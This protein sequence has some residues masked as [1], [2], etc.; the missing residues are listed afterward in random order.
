MYP[1]S[2]R[3]KRGS[4][5]RKNAPRS[6]ETTGSSSRRFADRPTPDK[7]EMEIGKSYGDDRPRK[8]VTRMIKELMCA[9]PDMTL[10]DLMIALGARGYKVSQLT[11]G[12][13]RAEFSETIRI[14][15]AEGYVKI[16]S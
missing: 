5:T 8:R 2:G 13:I 14:A 6:K 11:A 10:A 12:T 9:D 4:G 3:T 7:P 16:R 1:L 15:V